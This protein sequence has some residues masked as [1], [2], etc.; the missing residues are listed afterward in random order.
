MARRLSAQRPNRYLPILGAS[1]IIAFILSFVPFGTLVGIVFPILGYIGI[2]V[3]GLLIFT[4]LRRG[5]GI[6]NA[7]SRRRDKIRALLLRMIDPKEK[8]SKE[9]QTQLS[10]AVYNS[11][12]SGKHLRTEVANDVI[13]ELDEDESSSF[14][15]ED[16]QLDKDW[17]DLEAK[18]PPAEDLRDP[19]TEHFHIPKNDGNH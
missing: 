15:A 6:V 11:N 10:R 1:V 8:F 16:Y 7:E 14:H 3:I 12:L 4:W 17:Q 13:S 19:D 18:Q 2:I 9:D 5:R